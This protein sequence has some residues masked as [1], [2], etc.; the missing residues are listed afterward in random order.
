MDIGEVL[1]NAAF[2]SN[3]LMWCAASR[4]GKFLQLSDPGE[5]NGVPNLFSKHLILLLDLAGTT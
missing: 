2:S 3:K 5:L 4:L 1:K